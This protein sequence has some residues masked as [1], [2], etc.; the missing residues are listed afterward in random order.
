M[1]TDHITQ[2]EKKSS[3]TKRYHI[4]VSGEFLLSIHEDVL[5]KYGLYKGMPIDKEQI[6]ELLEAE[7]YN[8]VRQS[9]LRYLSYKPR[10]VQELRQ[11]L[12]KK[13][14]REGYVK[15]VIV[16]MQKLG[17]LDDKQY[18]Q[19]WIEERKHRKGYGSLRLKNELKRKG[20][21][22]EWIDEAISQ[23]DDNQ[24][25]QLAMEVAQRRYLRIHHESWPKIERKLGQFLQYRGFSIEVVYAT[26]QK[27][28]SM[29][30]GEEID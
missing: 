19:A 9:A 11:H 30:L 4:Y 24:E 22:P 16:E 29:H 17:Y 28:R 10:T 14:Y 1:E 27:I 12:A 6:Q 15:K 8:Q 2:I 26:L 20:I 13:E 3:I 21:A 25:R 18:A 7:E 5:V 23:M